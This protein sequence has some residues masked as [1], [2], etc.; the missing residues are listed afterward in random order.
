MNAQQKDILVNSGHEAFMSLVQQIDH[1]LDVIHFYM[2]RYPPDTISLE[3]K[4][5]WL[6]EMINTLGSKPNELSEVIRRWRHQEPRVI[7]RAGVEI[8]ILNEIWI[9]LDVL[10][11]FFDHDRIDV[12]PYNKLKAKAAFNSLVSVNNAIQ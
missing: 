7:S 12:H 9:T 1:M 2:T 8:G 4:H 3:H 10:Q 5:E 6:K 11:G